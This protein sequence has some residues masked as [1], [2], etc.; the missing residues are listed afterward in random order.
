MVK[1]KGTNSSDVICGKCLVPRADPVQSRDPPPG[2]Q[3][4][5]H[6]EELAWSMVSLGE[7]GLSA[8]PVW[9]PPVLLSP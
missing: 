3:L 1:V 4:L 6:S 7:E 8:W 2:L 9:C 5:K